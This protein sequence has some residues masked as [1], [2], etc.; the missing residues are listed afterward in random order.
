ML[1]D[2]WKP[3]ESVIGAED[4]AGAVGAWPSDP[5]ATDPLAV[6]R[7][8]WEELVSAPVGYALAGLS[9]LVVVLVVIAVAVGALGLG[10]APGLALD[11]E[12]ILI[13]GGMAGMLVYTGA[14]LIVSFVGYP[15]MTA[16]LMRAVDAHRAGGPA[17][18]FT[19]AF[20]TLTQDAGRIIAFYALSQLLVLVGMLFLYLPG[21][22]ALAVVTYALPMVVMERIG[23]AEAVS[24]S[25]DHLRRHPV[26]HLMVW[27]VLFAMLLVG[28][29][30]V[31]GLLFLWPLIAIYQLAAWRVT[32][33][34][35]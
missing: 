16:S 22:V 20:S 26:W 34:T 8:C 32:R 9:Y 30:T 2:A 19:S 13:V 24:R 17:P 27:G 14:I 33:E 7:V 29:L 10:V 12:T 21:F 4:L 6:A 1:D 18:G 23:A 25:F 11:D 15:L 3:P 28:E 35:A 31:V 5:A